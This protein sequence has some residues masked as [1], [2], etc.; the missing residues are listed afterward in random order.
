MKVL[1]IID[2]LNGFC[3]KG[4]PLSLTDS[5]NEIEEEIK[6][7][8]LA[9]QNNNDRYFFI[10]DS[11][12]IRDPEINNPYPPHC[13]Q[14][15]DEAKIINNLENFAN[16][17][18]ILTKNTLSITHNTG[19]VEI[20]EALNT[21]EIEITGVCTDICVLFAVYEL[22]IRGYKVIVNSKGVLPLKSENQDFFLNYMMQFLNARLI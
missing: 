22:R 9:Y 1:I 16:Q 13:I 7:R 6:S 19:L 21:T 14:G 20:L 12:S 3:R 15:T 2:M 5:T 4:N 8:I 10:C 11:H 18:N 17:D